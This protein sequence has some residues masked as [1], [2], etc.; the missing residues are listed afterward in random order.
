MKKFLMFSFLIFFSPTIHADLESRIEEVKEYVADAKCHVRY[1]APYA[2]AS[3]VGLGS[4]AAGPKCGT[5][6]LAALGLLRLHTIL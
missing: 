3:T 2:I 5:T 6:V 4:F 1:Y